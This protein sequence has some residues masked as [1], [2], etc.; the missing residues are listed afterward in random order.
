MSVVSVGE[1]A[2]CQAE[3]GVDL[4]ASSS[5][6]LVVI[7][8]FFRPTYW[9]LARQWEDVTRKRR[10]NQEVVM[11]TGDAKPANVRP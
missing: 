7:F 4:V 5:I 10:R 11:E 2:T 1:D 6:D 9:V 3:R 8:F